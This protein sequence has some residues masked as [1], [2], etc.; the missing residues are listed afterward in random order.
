MNDFITG[1]IKGRDS[2]KLPPIHINTNGNSIINANDE[3]TFLLIAEEEVRWSL[4][5]IFSNHLQEDG[6]VFDKTQSNDK[7][8]VFRI[9]KKIRDDETLSISNLYIDELLKDSSPVELL[10]TNNTLKSET[11]GKTNLDNEEKAIEVIKYTQP[12]LEFSWLPENQYAYDKQEDDLI[13]VD[14]FYEENIKT[15]YDNDYMVIQL[16]DSSGAKWIKPEHRQGVKVNDIYIIFNDLSILEFDRGNIIKD[17]IKKINLKEIIKGIF[18]RKSKSEAVY[19]KLEIGQFGLEINDLTIENKYNISVLMDN[20]NEIDLLGEEFDLHS[21]S[22]YNT[23]IED[24]NKIYSRV[25]FDMNSNYSVYGS[26]YKTSIPVQYPKLHI[27]INNVSNIDPNIPIIFT[28]PKKTNLNFD[29]NIEEDMIVNNGDFKKIK[30]NKKNELEVTIE[31]I[32]DFDKP[33]EIDNIQVRNDN[34]SF[35]FFK[36]E[37]SPSEYPL[38]VSYNDH[39]FESQSSIFVGTP[40]IENDVKLISW[41]LDDLITSAI[42][43]SFL[44]QGSK[45]FSNIDSLKLKIYSENKNLYWSSNNSKNGYITEDDIITI[46]TPGSSSITIMPLI[47]EGL[48]ELDDI[49][50]NGLDV[51]FTISY[52]GSNFSKEKFKILNIQRLLLAKFEEDCIINTHTR[53]LSLPSFIIRENKNFNTIAGGSYLIFELFSEDVILENVQ[54]EIV[55][56]S[57]HKDDQFSFEL[58]QASKNK[59][60]ILLNNGIKQNDKISINNIKIESNGKFKDMGMKVYFERKDGRKVNLDKLFQIRSAQI[61]LSVQNLDKKIAIKEDNPTVRFSLRDSKKFNG[62]S[63]RSKLPE[64]VIENK[65]GSNLFIKGN[66][67]AIKFPVEIKKALMSS[68]ETVKVKREQSATTYDS[69]LVG[70]SFLDKNR[71]IKIR[72]KK[73]LKYDDKLIIRNLKII[74]PDQILDQGDIIYQLNNKYTPYNEANNYKLSETITIVAGQPNIYLQ[75]KMEYLKNDIDRYLPSIILQEDKFLP[76][77]H[78]GDKINII[79]SDHYPATWS[80]DFS[81]FMNTASSSDFLDIDGIDWNDNKKITIPVLRDS[82]PGEKIEIKNLKIGNFDTTYIGDI[83]D[84]IIQIEVNNHY[85]ELHNNNSPYTYNY[86]F[87]DGEYIADRELNIGSIYLKWADQIKTPLSDDGKAIIPTL[88]LDFENINNVG[89]IPDTFYLKIQ[90]FDDV[91][92][93]V[94]KKA[95]HRY[96][97]DKKNITDSDEKRDVKILGIKKILNNDGLYDHYLHCVRRKRANRASGERD[98][99]IENLRLIVDQKQSS[100]ING[101]YNISYHH[102]FNSDLSINPTLAKASSSKD[103]DAS[104]VFCQYT[105]S[106]ICLGIDDIDENER[107]YDEGQHIEL[108]IYEEDTLKTEAIFSEGFVQL[109]AQDEFTSEGITGIINKKSIIFDLEEGLGEGIDYQISGIKFEIKG[110]GARISKLT[111]KKISLKL[112]LNTGS[113]EKEFYTYPP[114]ILYSQDFNPNEHL[115]TDMKKNNDESF[116]CYFEKKIEFDIDN[117]YPSQDLIFK[118]NFTIK[119]SGRHIA[120]FDPIAEELWEDYKQYNKNIKKFTFN[121][122]DMIDKIDTELN[123]PKNQRF[124]TARLKEKQSQFHYCLALTYF[125][126]GKLDRAG[127]HWGKWQYGSKKSNIQATKYYSID[128]GDQIKNKLR[129]RWDLIAKNINNKKWYNAEILMYEFEQ[130]KKEFKDYYSSIGVDPDDIINDYFNYSMGI[131]LGLSDFSGV[132]HESNSEVDNYVEKIIFIDYKN[133]LKTKNT[134][135]KDWRKIE[136]TYFDKSEKLSYLMTNDDVKYFIKASD[137]LYINDTNNKKIRLKYFTDNKYTPPSSIYSSNM[138]YSKNSDKMSYLLFD[139]SSIEESLPNYYMMGGGKYILIPENKEL[140]QEKNYTNK[141]VG[142]GFISLALLKILIL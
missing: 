142:W 13:K 141:L 61:T 125:L 124:H 112:K 25:L 7:N 8:I 84:Q 86:D 107:F 118:I 2:N 82:Q 92:E 74:Y 90:T 113:G 87:T 5:K 135:N 106:S 73:D 120:D 26:A 129:D 140:I 85:E 22:Y 121:D 14:L 71:T 100:E 32:I 47:I 105:G 58:I 3:Y 77:F 39:F 80:E 126:A 48:S 123:L 34:S 29:D 88:Y 114:L 133:W 41:P 115:K 136:N 36:D 97:W 94:R 28:L 6:Y 64:I 11:L 65:G 68:S 50:T 67:I 110:K 15:F 96:K 55:I 138:Y 78:K 132:Y 99:Q 139:Q 130:P 102:K 62:K 66:E 104:Y 137:S 109:K 56:E 38:E 49:T 70:F 75:K 45:F 51:F 12:Y 122:E 33:I 4:D 23:A 16:P 10:I 1:Y 117:E 53:Y 116:S 101:Y 52:D 98:L 111:R 83:E 76:N 31:N 9:N 134:Y 103:R 57:M 46:P 89:N 35:S 69:L 79:I 37:S 108:K 59:V 42:D 127:K 95:L 30:L 24:A 128:L 27:K 40:Q 60:K 81:D 18:R 21:P 43:I 17:V 54:D 93:T 20:D 91:G 44:E 72:L 63:Y 119:E 19:N 131:S